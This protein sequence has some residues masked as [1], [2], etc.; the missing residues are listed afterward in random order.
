MGQIFFSCITPLPYMYIRLALDAMRRT[1]VC[2][3]K[4]RRFLTSLIHEKKMKR[5]EQK[6]RTMEVKGRNKTPNRTIQV[7]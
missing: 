4:E 7:V 2:R 6:P 1:C 5:V 3:D